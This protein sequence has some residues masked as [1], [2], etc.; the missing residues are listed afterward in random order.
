VSLRGPGR[1]D[2]RDD[3]D[4]YEDDHPTSAGARRE[5]DP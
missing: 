4:D 1:L 2:E 5:R 3:D